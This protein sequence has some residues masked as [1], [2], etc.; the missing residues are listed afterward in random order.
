MNH[1]AHFNCVFS[2]KHSLWSGELCIA[3]AVFAWGKALNPSSVSCMDGS[4]M[5][6]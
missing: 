4:G 2:Q 1:T 6:M 3:P 5:G